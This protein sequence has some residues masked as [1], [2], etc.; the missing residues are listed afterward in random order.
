MLRTE[1]DSLVPS[2]D[3]NRRDFVQTA[4]GTGF[5]AAVLPVTAQTDHDRHARASLPGR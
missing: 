3:F 2:R 4:V 1:L 5:A